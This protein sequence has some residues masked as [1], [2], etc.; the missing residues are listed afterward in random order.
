[1]SGVRTYKCMDCKHSWDLPFGP[2]MAS[3]CPKCGSSKVNHLRE[4]NDPTSDL[5]L[6]SSRRGH[7]AGRRGRFWQDKSG[8]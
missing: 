4:T 7:S 5:G 8:D 2:I 6:D 3:N 1:M